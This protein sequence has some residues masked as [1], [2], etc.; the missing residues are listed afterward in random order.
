MH[1]RGHNDMGF[2]NFLNTYNNSEDAMNNFLGPTVENYNNTN[3]MSGALGSPSN[4]SFDTPSASKQV[5][6]LDNQNRN[7]GMNASQQVRETLTNSAIPDANN[8]YAPV[9]PLEQQNGSLPE[10]I[11]GEESMQ[12]SSPMS[13]EG[14]L[15]ERMDIGN[16]LGAGMMVG[17]N[18]IASKSL[19]DSIDN[20][21]EGL[22]SVSGMLS[23]QNRNTINEIK[24][25]ESNARNS[26]EMSSEESNLRLGTALNKINR[27]NIQTGSIK[28]LS[29][30][31]RKNLNS[32]LDST[33]KNIFARTENAIS[34]LN[35][36]NRS[37]IDKI[38]GLE[39]QLKAKKKQAQKDKRRTQFGTAIGV[40]S[41]LSDIFIPGSGQVLR[42]SYN[43]Y[44]R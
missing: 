44:N 19:D 18:L 20:I 31:V 11:S 34:R 29:D 3:Y 28:R 9:T 43:A 41:I 6:N 40:G 22:E 17:G 23:D 15:T 38:K 25:L 8:N 12:S 36:S 27:S 5:P 37:S 16:I 26:I 42:S 21:N 1:R 35:A 33:A 30:D 24:S 10:S 2:N 13:S 39:E 7:V 14:K 4:T 32:N